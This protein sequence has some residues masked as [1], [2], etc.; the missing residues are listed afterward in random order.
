MTETTFLEEYDP[1]IYRRPSVTVDL[2]LLGLSGN[3]LTVLL[4]QRTEHPHAGKWALP[5]GF[6]YIDEALD[7][8][9]LR[10]LREKVGIDHAHFE[11]LY[12]FGAVDRDPRMRIITVA[13]LA[14]MTE[15]AFADALAH[16][17]HLAPA[18]VDMSGV[19]SRARAV[20]VV[21]KD[22][23]RLSL[24]FDHADI[25][26]TAIVRLRGKLD[27]SDVGFAFLPP[28][29]TLRRL[30][31]VHEAISGEPI[32]KSA[33]RRRMIDKGWVVPT[34]TRETATAFRPA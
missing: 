22:G 23:S 16:A 32:N 8:A 9:A 20:T 6:V 11:Q 33:F 2:V 3:R 13:Y 31:D 17:P 25:L 1:E 27:Y 21:A 12:T 5:G 10:V 4:G 26:A 19:G 28:R 30:Q 24:A 15:A 14:L 34:G 18:S 7:D 29:F